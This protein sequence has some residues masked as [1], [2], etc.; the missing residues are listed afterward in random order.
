MPL[1]VAAAKVAEGGVGARC[2]AQSPP[3]AVDVDGCSP[4]RAKTNA[5]AARTVAHQAFSA[6]SRM[7]PA[8]MRSNA[9][10]YSWSASAN[11]RA[12][13]ASMVV[14]VSSLLGIIAC[15]A[16]GTCSLRS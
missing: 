7:S 8:A 15:N 12:D 13:S 1:Y 4:V 9:E 5:S 14:I 2:D 16:L 6:A 10:W 3:A 11:M